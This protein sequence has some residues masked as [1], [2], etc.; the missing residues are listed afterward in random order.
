MDNEKLF[1]SVYHNIFIRSIIFSF[2]SN[3][4]LE[5]SDEIFLFDKL[6]TKFYI[7]NRRKFKNIKKLS[8]LIKKKQYNLIKDKIKDLNS[9]L[10]ITKKSIYYLIEQF[11]NNNKNNDDEIKDQIEI[12]ELLCKFRKLEL[13]SVDVD[14]IEISSLANNLNSLKVFTKFEIPTTTVS[15]DH[16]I[17][18][19]NLESLEYLSLNRNEGFSNNL[20][21]DILMN[22]SIPKL[23]R[24]LNFLL[25]NSC[26]CNCQ[27]QKENEEIIDCLESRCEGSI[28]YK[29]FKGN[30]NL[31]SFQIFLIIKNEEIQN[32]LIDFEQV[33][34]I[35]S[36]NKITTLFSQYDIITLTQPINRYLHLHFSNIKIIEIIDKYFIL[37]F[38]NAIADKKATN[39]FL[40]HDF[41]QPKL[42]F[43][44][45]QRIPKIDNNLENTT[46]FNKFNSY[47]NDYFSPRHQSHIQTNNRLNKNN[48]SIDGGDGGGG[49]DD[50]KN[51][52][53][54]LNE[55]YF[56]KRNSLVTLFK[57]GGV[58]E[59]LEA[60]KENP[61][62]YELNFN[63]SLKEMTK[64]IKY[65]DI[66]ISIEL[67]PKFLSQS[68]QYP[69]RNTILN[70]L[71]SSI[72]NS[73]T[74]QFELLL[75]L[76]K[77]TKLDLYSS[78]SVTFSPVKNIIHQLLISVKRG[79]IKMY[80][81]L[82][83]LVSNSIKNLNNDQEENKI[84]NIIINNIDQDDNKN[85]NSDQQQQQQ[86]EELVQKLRF[87]I[88]SQTLKNATQANNIVLC[89]LLLSNELYNIY[90]PKD[91]DYSL[92]TSKF[93]NINFYN[94]YIKKNNK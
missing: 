53:Y 79:D 46:T 31:I 18:K 73:R 30:K 42:G 34:I 59:V 56:I 71:N 49:G 45:G 7:G 70:L 84:N 2:I 16:A 77:G 93:R 92:M 57:F 75:V 28:F 83:S 76:A 15:M 67:L 6:S 68:T 5:F 13:M 60:N 8:W 25:N 47:Y 43:V 44:N 62:Y 61:K 69:N 88:I 52:F 55:N 51:K 63:I 26:N 14:L 10:L 9:G 37:N 21:N 20:L 12:F 66:E 32:K 27:I 74:D 35:T 78:Y 89:E 50:H 87:K 54:S 40:N 58:K 41:V 82:L 64:I 85:N 86:Q 22:S 4:R 72:K 94:Y 80:E 19:C 1:W 24:L 33:E 39:H 11:N 48:N 3:G 17:T 91:F 36:V 29:F 81:Y 65:Y 23:E 38:K 90:I